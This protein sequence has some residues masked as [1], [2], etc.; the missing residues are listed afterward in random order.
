MN[1]K[2]FTF[3]AIAGMLCAAPFAAHA[4]G[5]YSA[6]DLTSEQTE[7]VKQAVAKRLKD[8]DSAKFPDKFSAVRDDSDFVAR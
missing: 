7:F 8:P 3:L 1:M 2:H 4:D 5:P 6:I